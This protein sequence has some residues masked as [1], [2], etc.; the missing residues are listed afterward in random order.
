M[1]NVN[2][3]I[4]FTAL[5][6]HCLMGLGLA[7]MRPVPRSDYLTRPLR[8]LRTQMAPDHQWRAVSPLRSAGPPRKEG[9]GGRLRGTNPRPRRGSAPASEPGVQRTRW[10]Q[11]AS[12]TVWDTRRKQAR[13]P[14]RRSSRCFLFPVPLSF[15]VKTLLLKQ[16]GFPGLTQIKRSRIPSPSAL[17]LTWKPGVP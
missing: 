13:E 14:V 5:S 11:P 4:D 10:P 8:A 3:M 15:A 9:Q 6:L 16:S 2:R 7:R 17:P 1:A 12:H